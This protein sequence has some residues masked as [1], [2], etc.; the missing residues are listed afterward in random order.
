MLYLWGPQK[1]ENKILVH[2]YQ[3]EGVHRKIKKNTDVKRAG[4]YTL[5]AYFIHMD[6]VKKLLDNHHSISKSYPWGRKRQNRLKNILN[7]P[8][9]TLFIFHLKHFKSQEKLDKKYK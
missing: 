5:S 6:T 8:N 2:F 4:A 3:N 9:R 7:V 1:A